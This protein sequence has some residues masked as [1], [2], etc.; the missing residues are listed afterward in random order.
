MKQ[1]LSKTVDRLCSLTFA[2]S[3]LCFV[4]V[5]SILGVVLTQPVSFESGEYFRRFNSYPEKHQKELMKLARVRQSSD[6]TCPEMQ[7]LTDDELL[8]LFYVDKYGKL[9][10]TVLALTLHKV[11]WSWWFFVASMLL[12]VCLFLCTIRRLPIQLRLAFQHSMPEKSLSSDTRQLPFD[13]HTCARKITQTLKKRGFLV[14]VKESEHSVGIT[15]VRGVFSSLGIPTYL[16][17]IGRFGPALT[18]LG[19][20]LLILAGLAYSRLS[21]VTN[22][23]ANPGDTITVPDLSGAKSLLDFLKSFFTGSSS[24]SAWS[25]LDWRNLPKDT[26]NAF[27]LKV[28]D[29]LVEFTPEGKPKLF[30][31]IAT[32]LDPDPVYKHNIEVNHPLIYKGIYFYQSTYN[33]SSKVVLEVTKPSDSAWKRTLTLSPSQTLQLE[34]GVELAILR[35]LP[36]FRIDRG[37]VFSAS[38]SPRNP[39]VL[40]QIDSASAW[41]FLRPELKTFNKRRIRSYEVRGVRLEPV[42]T[43]GLSVR[44]Q[45]GVSL[46]WLAS[47]L[48][49]IGIVLSLYFNHWKVSIFIE[50]SPHGSA[51]S[52]SLHAY[53]WREDFLTTFDS[54][55]REIKK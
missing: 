52:R 31:T 24:S 50:K 16:D 1:I 46:I 47:A 34:E 2:T 4:T 11:F 45:P 35:Y 32:V 29:F 27:Q 13:P 49:T 53:K 51:L 40:V 14:T 48:I 43:T 39:A 25:G 7:R 9:G 30:R 19:V 10:V 55:L 18:H 22:Q 5:A 6:D 42:Y 38:S 17:G 36:D 21:F 37:R 54:V 3:L 44:T 15:A 41:V 26:P 12:V 20:I 28:E 23:Y 8:R 33:R